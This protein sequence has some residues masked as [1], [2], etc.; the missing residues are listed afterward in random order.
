MSLPTM[1]ADGDLRRHVAGHAL[2]HRVEPLLHE[3]VLLA[4][5][6]ERLVGRGLDVAGHV[7]DLFEAL[8]L[9]Q[10]LGEAETGAGDGGERLGPPHEVAGEV[11]RGRRGRSHRRGY[12]RPSAGCTHVSSA[13]DACTAPLSPKRATARDGAAGGVTPGHHDPARL[14]RPREHRLERAGGR[15]Q[16]AG[17]AD[18]EPD[19]TAA[20]ATGVG[21]CS[22]RPSPSHACTTNPGASVGGP[23]AAD[24]AADAST[25]VRRRPWASKS[26]RMR[27][28]V[29]R[30]PTTHVPTAFPAL[31]RAGDEA[32][33]TSGVGPAPDTSRR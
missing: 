19:T 2:A 10:A 27:T 13:A 29:R 16:I 7:Q 18:A 23:P 17:P 28:P 5:H 31:A 9:V 26:T 20:A 14:R 3:V 30:C 33:V 21:A 22:T 32:P 12:P 6:L 11:G 25:P 4:P 1:A 24:G 15:E 8:A